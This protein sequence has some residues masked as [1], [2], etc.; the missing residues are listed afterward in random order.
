MLEN[1]VLLLMKKGEGGL[2]FGVGLF[3]FHSHCIRKLKNWKKEV[4][5]IFW[6][7]IT[8]A[9]TFSFFLFFV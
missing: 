7:C 2:D 6:Q 5:K 9:F 1:E 4:S 3:V 8:I